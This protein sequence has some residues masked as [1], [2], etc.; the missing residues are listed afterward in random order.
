M[1]GDAGSHRSTMS[2]LFT[3]IVGSTQRWELVPEMRQQVQQHF[4]ALHASVGHAGGRVFATMGDGVAAAFI[5][6]DAAVRAAI[7]AQL[8]MADIG[9]S[10][11]IGIHTGEVEAVGDDFLGRSVNRAARVMGLAHGGQILLS[12]VTAR[13]VRSATGEVDLVDLGSH[14]LRDLAEPE[15]LWQVVHSDLPADFPPPPSADLRSNNLPLQR[16]SLVGRAADVCAVAD[17]VAQ[18][19][20]VTL[21]GVGG[22]GKT[23][24][25]VQVAGELTTRFVNVA[26]IELASVADAGD[27]PGSIA[28][29][30]G[31]GTA[32]DPLRA[33]IT[34]LGDEQTLLIVDNCEH[35]VD[36]AAEAID[37]LTAECPALHVLATSREPLGIDGEHVKQVR[38]LDPATTASELFRQRAT[39]AGADGSDLDDAAIEHICERLDGIPLAIEL[40]AARASTLGIPAVTAA[41]DDRFSLLHGGRRRAVDR[42]ATMRAT[43][44]WSYRLLPLHAQRLLQ[45]LTV[46]SNGFELDAAHHIGAT[47]RMSMNEVTDEVTSL[48]HRSMVNAE[49]QPNGVRYRLLETMRAFVLERLDE[50]GERLAAQAALADWVAT[51]TDLS[52]D[53]PVDAAAE[54]ASL[55]LEREADNWRDAVIHAARVRDGALAA[56]LCGPPT[57]LFLLGR[58]DLGEHVAPLL[59]LVTADPLGRRSVLCA[60]A[61]ST[62]GSTPPRQLHEWAAEVEALDALRPCGA[63][64]LIRWLAYAWQGDFVTSTRLCEAASRDMRF[65]QSTRDLF[66]GIACLDHFSLTDA[67][68]DSFGLIERAIEVAA[69]SDVAFHRVACLLGAAWG[70]ADTDA[71]Q[72]LQFVRQATEHIE[73]VPALTRLTLPGSA[74]RLL[75]RLDPRIAAQGL[76][77]Q[78]ACTPARRSFVDAIPLVYATAVLHRVGHPLADS[79]AAALSLSSI[80]PYLSMMDFVALARDAAANRLV[81]LADLDSMIREALAE[82]AGLPPATER[83]AHPDRRVAAG[84][85]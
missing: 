65:S 53:E 20:I 40:A 8:A 31:A 46:F 63:G 4:T 21:T 83:R 52:V 48:V 37:V 71:A 80:A 78:L 66:V 13:L 79:A 55:R 28:R 14:R 24:L 22:V 6:A 26:F 51:I 50:S 75:A 32:T 60:L 30:I 23:R 74:S 42:H 72:A 27:V 9:L 11:R 7:D 43:I 62:S 38:S 49:P 45:R 68:D 1:T 25:A 34:L 12:D 81:S 15:R 57:A 29:S 19:R 82:I 44:D 10:V 59:P 5:S 47:L 3:D 35:V 70:L 61:V 58:H 54:R 16:S 56:R 64:G 36:A 18:H 76:L 69:R 17:L 39:A 2:L 85:D 33:A 41:L 84:A 73:D 67:T 77:E